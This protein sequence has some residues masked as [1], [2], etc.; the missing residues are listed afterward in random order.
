M[1]AEACSEIL[2]IKRGDEEGGRA[3]PNTKQNFDVECHQIGKIQK[4]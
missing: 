4:F 2:L 3:S 1:Y